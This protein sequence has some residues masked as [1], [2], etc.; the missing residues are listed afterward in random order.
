MSAKLHV[1]GLL[2]GYHAKQDAMAIYLSNLD[3]A[4]DA[5]D[6]FKYLLNQCFITYLNYMLLE[7]LLNILPCTIDHRQKFQEY[8]EEH[9]VLLCDASFD[10]ISDIFCRFPELS[11]KA[12]IGFPI[13]KINI[14]RPELVKNIYELQ[15]LFSHMIANGELA[16][17]DI[18]HNCSTVTYSIFP[19]AV[20]NLLSYF[21]DP[22][23][24]EKFQKLEISVRWELSDT[25]ID[26][27]I[28]VIYGA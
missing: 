24:V 17:A 2:Q 6:L 14:E 11:P 23:V 1:K 21:S 12:I 10:T 18:N 8:K 19:F 25:N 27:G 26:G 4:T 20:P 16:L 28:S 3:S 5:D 7:K 15:E 9:S 22:E 13:I